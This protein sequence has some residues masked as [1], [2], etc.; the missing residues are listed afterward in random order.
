MTLAA[1][2][3]QGSARDGIVSR[4]RYRGSAKKP[5]VKQRGFLASSC[6]NPFNAELLPTGLNGRQRRGPS[7]LQPINA[8]LGGS[9]LR[10]S[11]IARLFQ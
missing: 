1:R 3:G 2:A 8:V 9:E 6:R 7:G 5:N 4:T 10:V 11:R